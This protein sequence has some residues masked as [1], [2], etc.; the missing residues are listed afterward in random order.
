MTAP[1]TEQEVEAMA[2][3]LD[4]YGSRLTPSLEA[5]GVYRAAALLRR[6]WAE[7]DA[8][9]K[10][11]DALRSLYQRAFSCA[12]RLTNYVEDRPGLRQIERDMAKIEADYRAAVA[13][14][15]EGTK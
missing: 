2:S 14:L 1:I 11:R 13:Q 7:R 3:N 15:R 4:N 12:A 6:L 10:E 9:R 5:T 8:L